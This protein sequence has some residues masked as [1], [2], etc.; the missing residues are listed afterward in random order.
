MT[1]SYRTKLGIWFHF[2]QKG[3]FLGAYGPIGSRG[4]RLDM[5]PKEFMRSINIS[6]SS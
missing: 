4:T 3:K 6:T 2:H 5:L 1:H